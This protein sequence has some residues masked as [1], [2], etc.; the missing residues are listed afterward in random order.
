MV[1][2]RETELSY[3]STVYAVQA[4]DTRDSLLYEPHLPQLHTALHQSAPSLLTSPSSPSPSRVSGLA[5]ILHL[6][7]P[8]P[9]VSESGDRP[10]RHLVY[11]RWPLNDSPIFVMTIWMPMRAR[12]LRR[13]AMSQVVEHT[14][15]A[16]STLPQ[17]N[18]NY[19]A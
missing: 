8:C 5:C 4:E 14:H 9:A 19:L 17:A 11:P 10:L 15:R 18:G 3:K 7:S 2:L 12:R 16:A 6:V 13:K 1:D